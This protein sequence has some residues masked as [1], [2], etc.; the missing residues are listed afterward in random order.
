MVCDPNSN[1]FDLQD[2][3][4]GPSIPG[5]G[6]PFSFPKIPFPDLK[7]PTGIPEDILDLIERL[8][9]LFPAGIRFEVNADA[10]MSG[11]WD[12]LA[13][14]FNQLAPFLAWYKFI[15][16]LLEI[17][18]CIIDVLCALL[19]P[20]ALVKAMIRLFKRCLP[21]FLSMFPWLALLIMILALILLLIALVEYII[22][23]IL[24]YIQQII[25]NIKVLLRAITVADADAIFAAVTKF[26]NL[27]CLIEQ[28][29]AILLAVAALFAIIKPL[30]GIAG[31]SVCA[32]GDS[33][34]T[35]DF[36]PT[37][38]EQGG[39]DR[40]VVSRT[41]KF[42]YHR[43]LEP[44][45]PDDPDGLLSFLNITGWPAIREERWQFVDDDPNG[46]AEA[47]P[48]AISD[49]L[50]IERSEAQADTEAAADALNALSGNS[51]VNVELDAGGEIIQETQ[52][53]KFKFLDIITPSPE[54]GF[55]YWPDNEVYENNA[56]LIR[57]PYL[58]D[59]NISV[60]PREFGQDFDFGGPRF[61][62]I[63]NI[64]VHRRPTVF[65]INW[66]N[67]QPIPNPG[68]F[69]Q[70]LS[71][72]FGSA[73][74]SGAIQLVGG[75]VYEYN[76]EDGY[77]PYLIS[78]QIAT[79]ENFIHQETK[80]VEDY[81][82]RD[83]GY[84]ITDVQYAFRYNHEVLVDKKLIGLMCTP[85]ASVE[86]AAV[87]AEFDDLRSTLDKVGDL[88][89]VGSLTPDR[90]NG[91]GALGC[92]ARS[93]T[94]FR[95]AINEENALKFQANAIACLEDLKGQAEDFY[96]RGALAA[97][98]RYRSDFEIDPDL[99]FIKREIDV[100][101]TLRDRT[102]TQLAVSIPESVA[103]CIA[104]AL[105]A[106]PTFGEIT[107]FEYDGYGAF[108]AKLTSDKAGKGEL[109]AFISG[110][111]FAEVINRDNDDV[112]SEIIERVLSYEFIDKTSFVYRRNQGDDFKDRFGPP[113]IAE[114]GS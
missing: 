106:T 41:G 11:V 94:D 85:S 37:F 8:F 9:A 70:L 53:D 71:T 109:R 92:L 111:V 39:L 114:D 84:Y 82:S 45:R 48:S 56:N 42:I 35:E 60:D 66:K 81:P 38:I 95:Q 58:M 78:G 34:C 69:G 40:T 105:T 65:P 23:V 101:I 3:G 87:N 22:L 97:A 1:S 110:E 49:E 27:L 93:L 33:C 77:T 80:E 17:I 6:L 2:P 32:K 36:C 52:I 76:G 55:T 25:E 72:V 74:V 96:C 10:L 91:T 64:I 20:W 13:S 26:S 43:R 7:I 67:E 61:F 50:L 15:Q 44:I 21:N 108:V 113:D 75:E 51:P 102:G 62:N 112:T 86:T 28:L 14:L 29:F 31:R 90:T 99:Q 16:A 103:E 57:V 46:E 30:M 89:D 100:T 68:I 83:D 59:M 98:D 54:F 47:A 4:P 5:L 63:R 12:A 73:N 24:A 88:P 104:E 107:S 19:S 18:L 79:L